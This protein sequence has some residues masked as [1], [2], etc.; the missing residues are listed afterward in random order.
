MTAG[1]IGAE[2]ASLVLPDG[3]TGTLAYDATSVTLVIGGAG[4]DEIFGNGFELIPDR[5]TE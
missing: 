4:T 3:V 2:A 5:V 1:S